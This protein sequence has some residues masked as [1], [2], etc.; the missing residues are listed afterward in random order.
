MGV[1]DRPPHWGVL[2]YPFQGWVEV[3]V[4]RAWVREYS[5]WELAER[6]RK[7]ESLS[8]WVDVR[9]FAVEWEGI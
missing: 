6:R 3:S 4:C 7:A 2:L 8:K 9:D 1:N 5:L